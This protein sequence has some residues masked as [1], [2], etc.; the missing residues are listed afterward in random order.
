MIPIVDKKEM[1][2]SS[3]E[4]IG[5]Y[6]NLQM[7]SVLHDI[8]KFW[9]R[10]GQRHHDTYKVLTRDDFGEI[11]AHSKWSASFIRDMRLNMHIEEYALYH[12]K[13]TSL[14]ERDKLLTNIVSKADTYSCK[15]RTDLGHT[16]DDVR[17]E[18][19][20]S[21]FSNLK[22][23]HNNKTQEYYYPLKKLELEKLP[24]P[25]ES[26]K[27]AM[28]GWNLQYSYAELW[29]E[30][31]ADAKI[32]SSMNPVPFDTMY[33]LLKK[34]TSLMPSAAYVSY[35]DISLFDH[36]KTTAAIASCMYIYI[37]EK[38]EHLISDKTKYFTLISG[39]ISGIQNFIYNMSSPHF[40]QEGMA[41]RLRGR[42]FYINIL[43]ENLARIITERLELNDSNILWC[44][45]GSFLILAP[46]THNAEKILR[47][48][49]KEI[50]KF[51]FEK[52]GDKIFFSLTRQQVSGNE[53][54]NF[55]VLKENIF[56]NNSRKKRQKYLDELD[57][58][59]KEEENIP[60]NLCIICENPTLDGYVCDECK[61]HEE[62]GDK[63]TRADFIVRTV[64]TDGSTNGKF[65]IKELN[66][67]Y[68]LL[69]KENLLEEIERIHKSSS[70]IQV[71]TLNNTNFLNSEIINKLE[72]KNIHVSFGFS[73]LG[74]IIPYSDKFGQLNFDDIA[75][76]SKGSKKLG[77]LKMDIDNLGKL[78]ATGLG[79]TVS[80][81]RIS[82]MSSLLDIFVSGYIN[83]IAKEYYIL[84]EICGECNK[85]VDKI[86]LEISPG[87]GH[88]IYREKEKEGK[89]ERVCSK[90]S[91]KK[92]PII[93]ISYTG[94]DDLLII[95]PWDV[96]VK[97]SKDVRDRFKKYTCMNQDISISAGINICNPRYHI[98]KSVIVANDILKKSKILD[99][100]RISVFG[101]TVKWSS[102]DAD[103]GYDELLKFADLLERLIK[104]DKVSNSFVYSLITLLR[105]TFGDLE[106]LEYEQRLKVR[107]EQ[108][109]YVPILKYRL[110]RLV[111]DN[112]IKEDLNKMLVTE[113]MLPWVGI[114]ASIVSLKWR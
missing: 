93:Y 52:Y 44:G 9:L 90:C 22:I 26:K 53:L 47:E 111:K 7:A 80:I 17:K 98:G 24:F 2:G 32:V 105:S 97:F 34:Y 75:K 48:Y 96:I 76:I 20:I 84:P 15:E 10:T 56:Y 103:K 65:D 46:N 78:F 27:E 3:G 50:S 62:L 49:E 112:K 13:Y 85:K 89:I 95:G 74:N 63:I 51:L 42:S 18:P 6:Y 108:R 99:K 83:E 41:K 68:L 21:A 107:L 91:E 70:K 43:N 59:F 106:E 61:N 69:K 104:D 67:G 94:D 16:A 14:S 12:H 1:L 25:V 54:E 58:V 92:I 45:G 57:M 86:E 82:T 30:F 77:I 64:I 66:T 5:E 38:G 35:P 110:A 101:D 19:L 71:F 55:A 81:S 39:D 28:K 87:D 73:F 4:I 31:S 8:G 29:K 40:A 102:K 37:I 114:P 79:D 11:G 113:R 60:S 72:A 23:N 36:L 109:K 88:Y 33:Y 100:D